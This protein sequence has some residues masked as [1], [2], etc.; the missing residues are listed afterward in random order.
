MKRI[1]EFI[2]DFGFLLFTAIM[3]LMLISVV[4][5]SQTT[6]EG[7]KLIER[8]QVQQGIQKL[9][10]AAEAQP[11]GSGWPSA[12]TWYH[13]GCGLQE[14]GDVKAAAAAFDKGIAA[15]GKSA[16]NYVGK[17]QFDKALELTKSKDV[18]VLNAIAKAWLSKP[19]LASKAMDL[20]KK[21]ENMNANFET[22]ILLGDAFLQRGDGGAAITNYEH[23]A[24]YDVRNPM[25]YYRIGQVYLRSTNK[26]AALEAFNQAVTVDPGYTKAWK[27]IAELQYGFKRGE[28][29][30]KAQEKYLALT[31]FKD[32][33]RSNM[34]FYQFM[35]RDFAK[36]ADAFEAAKQK[37]LLSETGLKYYAI[38]LSETGEYAD[39]RKVFEEYFQK[40]NAE[41]VEAPD[42]LTY[43]KLLLKLEQ[44]SLAV[45]AFDRSLAL[46][47]EQ[48][49]IKQLK[50]ETLFKDKRYPDATKAYK[51]LIAGRQKPTSQD[52]YSLGRAQYY[53]S[54]FPQADTTFRKLIEFQPSMSVG[55]LWAARTNSNLDPESTQGLAKPFYEKVIELG[56]N[57]PDKSKAELK[58][59][60]SYLGYYYLLK[61]DETQSK[62][63]WEKVLA[64]DPADKRAMEAMKIV[65]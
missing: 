45:L 5:F 34:G 64:I 15:D 56:Q 19:E 22:S 35:A 65:K 46:N 8:E 47:G 44:D 61:K 7:Q 62:L 13:L 42:Y 23:A 24:S 40:A 20:L 9:K 57:T 30:V 63:N 14:T 31:D 49:P 38:A 28:E 11:P 4:A 27:E 60:F 58:E 17:G 26:D 39:A 10:S 2:K 43:G 50:A 12:I 16:L 18:Q 51:E 52:L 25:P 21:A 29:A 55:Y 1:F 33:A 32:E 41:Q 48:M 36:S 53:S 59:A 37:G 6:S 3:F 54:A